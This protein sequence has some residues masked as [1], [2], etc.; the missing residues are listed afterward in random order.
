MALIFG[1]KIERGMEIMRERNRR[2]LEDYEE[3]HLTDEEKAARE[4]AA[5]TEDDPAY[6]MGKNYAFRNAEPGEGEYIPEEKET[7][8]EKGDLFAILVSSF[9]VFW[10]IFLVLFIILGLTVYWITRT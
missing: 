3:Q 7:E 10:P 9:L 4:A 8:F 2:Y 6:E 5:E 1:K